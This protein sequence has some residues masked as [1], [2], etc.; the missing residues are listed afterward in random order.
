MTCTLQVNYDLRLEAAVKAGKYDWVDGYISD[1]HFPSKRS[2][3]AE[4]GIQL[5]HF[6]KVMSSKDILKE[7]DEMGLRPAELSELLAFGAKYPDEQRKY[8]IV[9]LGSVW[10]GWY[11]CQYVPCLERCG[12]KRGLDSRF[13]YG[14]NE[15][16]RFLAVGK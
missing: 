3:L 6:N 15:C 12:G 16:N 5:V 1:K 11:D 8:P 7:L 13:A 10:H 2:G 4:I 9:A 14:W